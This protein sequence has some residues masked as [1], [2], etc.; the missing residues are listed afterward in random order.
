[1]SITNYLF[2]SLQKFVLIHVERYGYLAR[3]L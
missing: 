1:L 2:L 3:K